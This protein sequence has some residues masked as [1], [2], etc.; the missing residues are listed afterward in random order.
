MLLIVWFSRAAFSLENQLTIV[1]LSE[2]ITP[3]WLLLT[4]DS[5]NVIVLACTFLYFDQVL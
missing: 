2:C 1:M 3:N 4:I 5:H